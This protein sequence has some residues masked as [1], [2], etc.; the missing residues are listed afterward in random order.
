MI[1]ETYI[2]LILQITFLISIFI[3]LAV[4]VSSLRRN[5][6]KLLAF[7]CWSFFTCVI[8]VIVITISITPTSESKEKQEIA[9]ITMTVEQYESIYR[10]YYYNNYYPKKG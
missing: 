6:N 3:S 10:N 9:H 5:D 1:P 4:I 8:F 2:I 7:A